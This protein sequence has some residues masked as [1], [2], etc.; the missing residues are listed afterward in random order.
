LVCFR[1]L[2]GNFSFEIALFSACA[3]AFWRRGFIGIFAS[4]GAVHI[5]F[6]PIAVRLK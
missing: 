6:Q 1:Y 3:A 4:V 2:W 5:D